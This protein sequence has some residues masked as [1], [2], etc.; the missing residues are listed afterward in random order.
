MQTLK[1]KEG[2]L[3]KKTEIYEG[4]QLYGKS[5]QLIL[6]KS[7]TLDSEPAFDSV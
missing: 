7:S 4:T 2:F 6:L 3:I 5:E 1:L